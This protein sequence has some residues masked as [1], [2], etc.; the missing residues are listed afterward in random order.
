MSHPSEIVKFKT[1]YVN[2]HIYTYTHN[3]ITLQYIW[4]NTT[5]YINYTSIKKII[6]SNLMQK[7]KKKKP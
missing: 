5:L 6:W 4:N 7:K 1:S 3:G 2:I